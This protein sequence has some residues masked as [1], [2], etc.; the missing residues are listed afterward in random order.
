MD[1][2]L[3]LYLHILGIQLYEK[4]MALAALSDIHDKGDDRQIAIVLGTMSDSLMEES[5]KCKELSNYG[6]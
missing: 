6:L 3:K 1:A 2:E 4:S 5:N